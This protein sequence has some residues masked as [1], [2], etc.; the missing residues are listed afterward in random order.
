MDDESREQLLTD[1]VA[2]NAETSAMPPSQWEADTLAEVLTFQRVV[3]T[4][5]PRDQLLSAG[6]APYNCHLN[7]AEHTAND[8][9]K[10]SRHVSGWLVHGYDLILHSVVE[11][12]GQWL[13]L[14]PQL[15]DVAPQFQFIPDA[16]IDWRENAH[17]GKDPFRRGVAVPGVL[18][19]YP[20]FHVRM[21]AKFSEL[22]ASGLSTR[23]AAAIVEATIGAELRRKEP[24]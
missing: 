4:R 2:L 9:E 10:S 18:R 20:E 11:M 6:F 16:V 19:K 7:C 24:I 22:V 21:S 5:P 3:V 8:P 1:L 14:T 13:C 23:E 17:G 15:V 12:R